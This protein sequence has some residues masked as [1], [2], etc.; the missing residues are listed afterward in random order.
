MNEEYSIRKMDPTKATDE[1]LVKL[2]DLLNLLIRE[3]DKDEPLPTKEY[4]L[5]SFRFK[6]PDFDEHFWLVWKDDEV[7][8]FSGLTIRTKAS[9]S[10]EKNK[11]VCYFTIRIRKEYR[12]KGIGSKILLEIIKQ[13]KKNRVITTLECNT[14]Y[15]SGFEFC[16]KLQGI[17]ALESIENRC[18][19]KEVNWEMMDDWRKQGQEKGKLEGR[20]LQW[21]EKCPEEIIKEY[22]K[23]YTETMNQQPLGLIETR[24]KITP[25]SRRKQEQDYINLGY[26]W[27]TVISRE[28]DDQISGVTDVTYIPERGHRIYQEL[29]G[30][31]SEFRK[32][33]IGKWLKAEMLFYIKENYPNVQYII[34]GNASSNA[35]ML[36]INT[37]MGFKQ[38][39]HKK[40][41]MFKLSDLEKRL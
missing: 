33:G 40:T 38:Y 39:E 12:R 28:N 21:F 30:V 23:V 2:F 35:A 1:E 15:E 13:A 8:G 6:E 17:L 29:T 10:Y 34:T 36:S 27:Y 16:K 14:T 9:V 25:K 31:K 22:T 7:I 18:Y 41:Y 3:K 37:R 32:K 19:L 26:I 4:R 11:H 24:A 5:K 20:Y